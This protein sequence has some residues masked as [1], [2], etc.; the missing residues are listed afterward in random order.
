MFKSLISK[1]TILGYVRHIL[2]T[3]GG[4]LVANGVFTESMLY[5]SVGSIVVL[6]GITWSAIVKAK[7]VKE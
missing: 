1:T 3:L 6:V 2:T 7:A 4:A 5:E